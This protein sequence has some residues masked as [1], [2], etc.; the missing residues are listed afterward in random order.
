VLRLLHVTTQ[1]QGLKVLGCAA[2]MYECTLSHLLRDTFVVQCTKCL[3]PCYT[4]VSLLVECTTDGLPTWCGGGT[5]DSMGARHM[6]ACWLASTSTCM[7]EHTSTGLT[8]FIR[9]G[10]AWWWPPPP[11]G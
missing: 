1:A 11:L 4:A 10:T 5:H 9:P 2:Y 6:P 8:G 3:E 7:L